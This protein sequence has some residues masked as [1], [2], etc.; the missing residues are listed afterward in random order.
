MTQRLR[1]Q[2]RRTEGKALLINKRTTLTFGRYRTPLSPDDLVIS[3]T[4]RSAG[5]TSGSLGV[6]LKVAGNQVLNRKFRFGTSPSVRQLRIPDNLSDYGT[7]RLILT[8]EKDA[9]FYVTTGFLVA[10][11]PRFIHRVRHRFA[12]GADEAKFAAMSLTEIDVS[13]F[14]SESDAS[15]TLS[16]IQTRETG[17]GS[18]VTPLGDVANINDGTGV[19]RTIHKE[20]IAVEPDWTAQRDGVE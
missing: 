9:S 19:K 6:R 7:A 2:L 12:T 15:A 13:A 20:Q 11:N 1:L 18:T 10:A 14:D 17:F 16:A 3:L 4:A 8:P 5:A